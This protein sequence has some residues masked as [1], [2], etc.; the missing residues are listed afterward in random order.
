MA[1]A[2]SL[3]IGQAI[4]KSTSPSCGVGQIHEGRFEGLLVPGDGVTAALL[5]GAGIQVAT[6]RDLGGLT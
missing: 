5:K 4:L 3:G 1:L 6:D 2:G